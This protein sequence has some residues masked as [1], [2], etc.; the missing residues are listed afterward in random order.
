MEY[1]F[2]VNLPNV[3]TFQYFKCYLMSLIW[4]MIRNGI[5]NSFVQKR[6]FIRPLILWIKKKRL[7]VLKRR[8]GKEK[9]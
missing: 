9:S 8:L 1:K 7:L 5:R 6:G 2:T 3:F 4:L